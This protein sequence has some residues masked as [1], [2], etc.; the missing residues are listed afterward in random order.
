[1][2]GEGEDSGCRIGSP[3]ALEPAVL[4]HKHKVNEKFVCEAED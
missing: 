3:K 4:V 2:G 1:M